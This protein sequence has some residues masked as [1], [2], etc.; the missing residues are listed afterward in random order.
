MSMIYADSSHQG[1]DLSTPDL[2]REREIYTLCKA[3]CWMYTYIY[4]ILMTS[5]LVTWRKSLQMFYFL[6]FCDKWKKQAEHRKDDQCKWIESKLFKRGVSS[7]LPSFL[8]SAAAATVPSTAMSVK[9]DLRPL[10][11]MGD[12][13][14]DGWRAWIAPS[15][16]EIVWWTRCPC[17]PPALRSNYTITI[18]PTKRDRERDRDTDDDDDCDRY[19]QT[20]SCHRPHHS[21]TLPPFPS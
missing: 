7:F 13:I 8:P 4:L 16:Y 20:F 19:D 15:F 1:V 11:W 18:T 6:S 12:G 5:W 10:R 9:L 21:Q 3:W 2:E 17:V 14:W